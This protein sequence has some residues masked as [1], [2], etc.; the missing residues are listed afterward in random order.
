MRRAI[1]QL[2]ENSAE[3]EGMKTRGISK[4]DAR[5]YKRVKERTKGY[6]FLETP[7]VHHIS[8]TAYRY[9]PLVCM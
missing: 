9:E 5:V 1:V 8:C 2:V 6:V 7:L 3:P 4:G